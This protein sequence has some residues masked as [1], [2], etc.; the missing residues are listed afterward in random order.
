MFN[1]KAIT[2]NELREFEVSEEIKSVIKVV[3]NW[4]AVPLFLA[5]WPADLIYVPQFKWQF[6]ALRLSIIPVC[7]AAKYFSRNER[8]SF[9]SQWIASLYALSVALP[10]NVM[11]AYIPDVTTGYYAGLNM[12]AIGALSFIPYTLSFFAFTTAGIYL[13]YFLIVLFKAKGID[14][15]RGVLLNTFF[16]VG[17]IIICF[18]IRFFNERLRV[19]EINSRLAL[20]SEIANRDILIRSKTEEA[21]RLNTLSTQFSPQVVQAIRDGR[22][23]IEKGV[24]RAQICAIFVDIVGSTE[25]VV[26]LDQS[27]VDLV[28]ARFMDTVV[29]VF[30][31]Y[32]LTI[33]KFQG[34]G[35]LA[36]A[37]DPIR[38][39]D[40][41]QRTCLASLE[42]REALGKD[43]D[44]YLLNWKKEMQ[45]RIGIS[46]GYANVGF[47]GNKKFFRCY[48]AIGA[49]LPFA[50]RLT[51]LAEPNQILIDSDIAQ[52]LQLEGYNVK[53]IGEKSIKGFEDDQH[54]VFELHHGPVTHIDVMPNSAACPNCVDSILFLDT[55]PQGIFVMKCRQCGYSLNDMT[56]AA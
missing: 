11:I 3:A 15:Y 19:R 33:D 48:T 43:R 8:S 29:S 49:P 1:G 51:N 36:F 2:S 47:Y 40:F 53:S 56:T 24:R 35:I 30:L 18:L 55:N 42:V 46:A 27:K 25:R 5:F 50:S 4:M 20:K 6:L 7:F 12:V 21:V 28:L 45:I 39:S 23:D 31:K 32:D 22:V 16:I 13:P 52:C 14:D 10:I 44:F 41:M 54:I 17:S 37:N 9:E 26:R 34:D 38:Y